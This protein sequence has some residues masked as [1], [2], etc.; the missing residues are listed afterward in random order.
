MKGNGGM[1][2]KGSKAIV[3]I[4]ITVLCQTNAQ[5]N[6]TPPTSQIE[7]AETESITIQ[8]GDSFESVLK[9]LGEPSVDCPLGNGKHALFY[10]VGEVHFQDNKVA[11]F[12]LLTAEQLAEK[13]RL[14]QRSST[15][16]LNIKPPQ[17]QHSN[18]SADKESQLRKEVVE[19]RHEITYLKRSA[20]HSMSISIGAYNLMVDRGGKSQVRYKED[21]LESL[22]NN[23]IEDFYD[24]AFNFDLFAR[25]YRQNSGALLAMN[26][27]DREYALFIE[28]YEDLVKYEVELSMTLKELKKL[29]TQRD[30]RDRY[31]Y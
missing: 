18:A 6:N 24:M 17:N 25:R 30:Q 10:E 15:G 5:T 13:R 19:L 16:S 27:L 4:C 28:V 9:M 8:V 31:G 23:N 14:S 26:S 29:E 21:L 11:S 20:N 7:Q 22:P 12:S 3:T 2:F 1:I